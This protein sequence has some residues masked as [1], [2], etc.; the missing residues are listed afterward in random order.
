MPVIYVEHP[1]SYF[2]EAA[3][4]LGVGSV[5]CNLF[6]TALACQCKRKIL[7]FVSPCGSVCTA[8]SAL[9]LR[10]LSLTS[11]KSI[12]AAVKAASFLA[13]LKRDGLITLSVCLHNIGWNTSS[14][15][16]E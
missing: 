15:S 8:V 12:L 5:F 2:Q 11:S 6:T 9:Q 13:E 10:L 14:S 4:Q 16:P 1:A 3:F 7:I